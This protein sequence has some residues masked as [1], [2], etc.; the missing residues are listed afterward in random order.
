MVVHP[1]S[2]VLIVPAGY[3]LLSAVKQD[4]VDV[5]AFEP[6]KLA[7]YSEMLW[8]STSAASMSFVDYALAYITARLKSAPRK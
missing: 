3:A 2:E 8:W 7:K 6:Q 4:D 5:N 1:V